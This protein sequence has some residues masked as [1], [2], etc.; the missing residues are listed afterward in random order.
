MQKGSVRNVQAF[1]MH[2]NQD[3]SMDIATIRCE[4]AFWMKVRWLH[5]LLVVLQHITGATANCDANNEK[6][7][8][9]TAFNKSKFE[10]TFIPKRKCIRSFL[11]LIW[12]K[13]KFTHVTRSCKCIRFGDIENCKNGGSSCY[14]QWNNENDEQNKPNFKWKS[15]FA[16]EIIKNYR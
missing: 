11:C 14:E 5:S 2:N 12:T 3:K 15:K 6:R 4:F 13:L 8:S 10:K 16:Q 7:Q 1:K 9:E